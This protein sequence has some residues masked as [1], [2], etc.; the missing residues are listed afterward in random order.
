MSEADG[1]ITREQYL[2]LYAESVDDN[3]NFWRREGQRID[4]MRPYTRVKDVSYD[5]ADLHIR[6]YYDGAL[7]AS[8]NCID[9]HLP[10][11]GDK[12]A[13]LWEGDNGDTRHISYRELH[14]EVCRLANAL[15]A[16]GVKK[17]DRVTIY[18]PMVPEAVYAML[19]CA[20]IGAVHSVVFGGFS[21][22]ALAGRIHDCDSDIVITADEGIRGGRRIPLKANVDAACRECPGVRHVLVLRR[23]GGDIAWRDGRDIWYHDAIDGVSAECAP[24]E[25]DAE[26]PLFILYTS[27]TVS[28]THL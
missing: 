3:E 16:L 15:L 25:M 5:A 9:R 21:P 28:F 23:S 7:N 17:G 22:A 24:V 1:A 26:D 13:I 6:W 12:T 18:M 10:A 11:R 8:A 2:R 14:R 4:W 20:R 27:G 19:A